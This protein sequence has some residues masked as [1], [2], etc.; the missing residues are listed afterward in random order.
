VKANDTH[1]NF[2]RDEEVKGPPDRQFGVVFTIVFA[3]VAL[4][5]AVWGRPVRWWSAAVAG[6]FLAAA[7]LAPRVLAPLNRVWLWIGLLLHKCVSPIVLG[8]VFFSTVTP[9]ALLLRALGKDPLRLRFDNA[10]PTYWIARRP[11]GPAGDSMPNQ[12]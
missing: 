2:A 6:A 5:P 4:W 1:E 7:L 3:I 8:L 9:I 10:A 11:P 12:F